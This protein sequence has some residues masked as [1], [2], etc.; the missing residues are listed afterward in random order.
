MTELKK[1]TKDGISYWY[2]DRVPFMLGD[3][4]I[5]AKSIPF[6]YKNPKNGKLYENE[7][8]P[9]FTE[10]QEDKILK[11][12]LTAMH[13]LWVKLNDSLMKA[14][15]G[16]DINIFSI[17]NSHEFKGKVRL[18]TEA[19][20]M[21]LTFASSITSKLDE[22]SNTLEDIGLIKEAF[23]L[24]TFSDLYDGW[25][26]NEETLFFDE[27]NNRKINPQD[28]IS[29]LNA[30]VSSNR[31]LESTSKRSGKEPGLCK[32]IVIIAKK[33]GLL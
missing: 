4:A 18:K 28:A 27:L 24:D 20:Q 25:K 31:M 12:H 9:Y 15:P 26:S 6:R 29:V 23:A 14:K 30:Y 13:A 3:I 32:E 10:D 5:N 17:M 11:E 19:P 21:R 7:I 16:D 1:G 33:F 22:I 8:V 2:A